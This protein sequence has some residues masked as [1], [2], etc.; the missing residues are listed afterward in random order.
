MFT[1]LFL[2]FLLIMSCLKRSKFTLWIHFHGIVLFQEKKSIRPT[3]SAERIFGGTLLAMCSNDFICFYDWAECRL[4]HRIDVNVKVSI[5]MLWIALSNKRSSIYGFFNCNLT[6]LHLLSQNL[7]W[8]DSGD[9]FAIA[10]DTSFYILKY[11]V[12]MILSLQLTCV[13]DFVQYLF[14]YV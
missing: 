2:F 7:Y 10:S 9:I 4:I 8:A 13:I 1:V 5:F 11:N 12:R 14:S 6:F 3:F